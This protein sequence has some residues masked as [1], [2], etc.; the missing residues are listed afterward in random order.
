VLPR[1]SRDRRW[2][3][4]GRLVP[5]VQLEDSGAA[6]AGAEL[7]DAEPVEFAGVGDIR[8]VRTFRVGEDGGLY[9][10]NSATAWSEG[11]NTAT[12]LRNS[13]HHP[14]ETQ[15]RCGFYAYSHPA[16]VREQPPARNVLGV[17]AAHGTM[18]VGTRGA[19]V[20]QARVEA[21]WFGRRVSQASAA[22]V[23]RRY[24]SVTIYRDRAAMLAAHP[25]TRLEYF[26]APRVGDA[27]R[28][29]LRVA[30]WTFLAVAA[31]VG[32]V[33]ASTVVSSLPGAIVWLSLILT[34]L[35]IVA[36][37]VGQ[38]SSVLAVQG[39]AA[40]GWLLTANP[41]TAS[42]WAGRIGLVLMMGCVLRIWWCAA[43][44]GRQIRAPRI[45]RFARRMWG[46]QPGTP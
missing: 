32:C 26:R 42:G 34:G 30:M 17:V 5:D 37:G 22:A 18:E 6:R 40:L 3:G 15:C 1:W 14:P 2:S 8:M 28:D 44:P 27:A 29:R 19:R 46:R 35:G 39:V 9:P 43:T 38:K 25:L 23:R 11:W 33:P 24:P 36:T 45:E 20:E 4:V 41:A 31:A 21:L 16:Y 7:D 12:C 10:V 13:A